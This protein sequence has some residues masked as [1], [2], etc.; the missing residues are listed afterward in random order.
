M[1][2]KEYRKSETTCLLFVGDLNGLPYKKY[3]NLA[4]SRI[5]PDL[6]A[7]VAPHPVQ[8]ASLTQYLELLALVGTL[9]EPCPS[10]SV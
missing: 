9:Q 8:V 5:Y 1:V 6:K 4:E 3:L 7:E 2:I 10:R